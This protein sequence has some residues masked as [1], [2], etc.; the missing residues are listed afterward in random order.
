MDCSASLNVLRIAGTASA[1]TRMVLAVIAQIT[2]QEI[3]VK[4]VTF[5]VSV[6]AFFMSISPQQHNHY[7]HNIIII[8]IAS[9]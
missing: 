7:R 9:S 4:V 3:V 1:I 8:V 6:V 5:F 2:T